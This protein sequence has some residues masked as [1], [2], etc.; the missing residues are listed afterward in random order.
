MVSAVSS[1]Q[2][3][4]GESVDFSAYCMQMGYKLFI[5]STIC[6]KIQKS[7]EKAYFIRQDTEKMPEEEL[8]QIKV[9]LKMQN[10]AYMFINRLGSYHKNLSLD[11]FFKIKLTKLATD[12]VSSGSWQPVQVAGES[13]SAETVPRPDF[14]SPSR[15]E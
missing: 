2:L 14:G 5:R 13:G 15:D 9:A 12:N 8:R 10:G 3:A 1:S 11:T 4:T 7:G 6:K